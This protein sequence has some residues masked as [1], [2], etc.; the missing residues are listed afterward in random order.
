MAFKGMDERFTASMRQIYDAHSTTEGGPGGRNDQP[1]VEIKP[2]DKSREDT[3]NDSRFLPIGSVKRDLARLGKFSKSNAGLMFLVKQQTLQTGNTFSETRLL[4]PLFVMGNVVPYIHLRRPLSTPASFSVDSPSNLV[5]AAASFLTGKKSTATGP[6]PASLDSKIGKAGR[7]QVSTSKNAT[8][9]VMGTVGAQG[10]LSM[11]PP[12]KIVNAITGILSLKDQGSLGIN[13]RPEFN[14]DGKGEY[15]SIALWKGTVRKNNSLSSNV[16]SAILSLRAGNIKGAVSNIASAV[17]TALRGKAPN[18]RNGVRADMAASHRYFIASATKKEGYFN[19]DQDEASYVDTISAFAFL[20][21]RPYVLGDGPAAPTPFNATLAPKKSA[22]NAL[23]S[24]RKS[25]VSAFN[26]AVGSLTNNIVPTFK[27]NTPAGNDNL[28]ESK[29]RFKESSLSSMYDTDKRMDFIKDTLAA[30]SKKSKAYWKSNP[31]GGGLVGDGYTPTRTGDSDITIDP[32]VRT[33]H[34]QYLHDNQQSVY[35]KSG[36]TY[37]DR[38]TIDAIRKDSNDFIDLWF[39]DFVNKTTI[40]FRAFISN[41]NESVKPE[42]S[43]TRYV[44]RIERNVVYVGT[45]REV[46]FQLKLHAFNDTEMGKLYRKFNYLTGLCY[47]SK[48][49]SGFMVPPFVK[50]TLGDVYRDQPGYLTSVTYQIE[51][52]ISW[53]IDKKNNTQ[54]PHGITANI[55]FAIIEKSQMNANSVFYPFGVPR[56]E[57]AK[58]FANAVPFIP[59]GF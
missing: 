50:L 26:T 38:K 43:D 28:A 9:R 35:E 20:N 33:G 14:V 37:T 1:Y 36:T 30:Q 17:S 58:T 22:T 6:S 29:M 46:S 31:M 2:Y 13:E 51:D 59:I 5:S 4:N 12:N 7:L 23:A 15:F 52:G 25:V 16:E 19:F 54:A 39:F 42:M 44:G 55:A 41:I 8:G 56:T 24:I 18:G 40:P 3:K 49:D 53:E 57:D 47:P 11:L 21:R 10:L 34:R 27:F 48:Y 45:S 32:T